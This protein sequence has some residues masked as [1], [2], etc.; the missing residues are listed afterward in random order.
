MIKK[1]ALFCML[2]LG[3]LSFLSLKA[4]SVPQK[5]IDSLTT[6]IKKEN[7]DTNQVK[8]LLELADVYRNS[9]ID[10]S[11]VLAKKANLLAKNLN[12]K[13]GLARSIHLMGYIDYAKGDFTPAREK[14]NQALLIYQELHDD[15]GIAQMIYNLGILFAYTGVN[16]KALENFLKALKIYESTKNNKGISECYTVMAL[17][18]ERQ[19]NSDKAILY[20]NKALDLALKLN[21]KY[22]ISVCYINIGNIYGHQKKFDTSL[23]FYFKGLKIAE[24]LQNKKWMLSAT[25]NIGEIYTQQG[26]Y[27][28]ALNYLQKAL[29]ISEE[30]GDKQAII[31]TLNCM[32]K[33]HF[34]LKDYKKAKDLN[35]QALIMGKTI[36]SKYDIKRSYEALASLNAEMGNFEEA[37]TYHKLYANIKDTILNTENSKQIAEMGTKYETEKKDTEIKLL[38]KDKEIQAA[39]FQKQQIITWLIA[40]GLLIVLLLA[41]FI[42]RQY[43]EKQKANV[44]LEIAYHQI[45]E[46]NKDIT[47]S[48][49][50]ARRIQTAILP[51]IENIKKQFPDIF[52]FYQPK[53]IVSGDFYWF[54]EKNGICILAVADCTGHGVPGAFMSMIGND[55]LTQIVIEKGITQPNVILTHLHEGVK[56]ALKQDVEL[57]ETRDGMDIVLVKYYFE[58]GKY[59]L[60]YSGALRPLW[61]ISKNQNE[62]TEYKPDKH[63]IGGADSNDQ[64]QFTNHTIVLE[65]GDTFYLST[66]GYADQFGGEFGKK[67]M[68]KNMKDL[69]FSIQS[70]TMDQQKDEL[71]KALSK[72]K[73]DR[74]QVDDIL[75]IGIRV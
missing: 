28:E 15:S 65:K 2:F 73:K 8:A 69:L 52:I 64:R 27:K 68:T 29:D 11:G 13:K 63:S 61:L 75:V 44:A 57:N 21:D 32:A 43:R 22:N 74:Q 17:I 35:E 54:T 51:E 42:F 41:L 30:S 14:Y 55:M 23:V 12:Y 20:H 19:G 37:Y 66:D 67:M 5:K 62:L 60:E 72:W 10:T 59:L 56:Y 26:K 33:V 39:N 45:E 58:D 71:K 4:Q 24:E 31:E 46:K 50:Y 1:A 48:I 16:D 18:Y 70:L 3:L 38:N 34:D 47:D 36:G 49:N 6:L 25:G 53:D 7:S 40:F 9:K